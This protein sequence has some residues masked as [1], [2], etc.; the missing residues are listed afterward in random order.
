MSSTQRELLGS[1]MIYTWPGRV[2]LGR[3]LAEMIQAACH[4]A[5]RLHFQFFWRIHQTKL[6]SL[7][8][9]VG[10]G[11]MLTLTSLLAACWLACR[12]TSHVHILFIILKFYS[13]QSFFS[14]LSPVSLVNV[15]HPWPTASHKQLHVLF[16]KPPSVLESV[17]EDW[18]Q[19][20]SGWSERYC[21]GVS[22]TDVELEWAGISVT[23]PIKL[24]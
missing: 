16:L 11:R 24:F 14:P 18:R 3:K 15:L 9:Q 7:A 8:T 13:L 21:Q 23:F 5:P 22:M 1:D 6:I 2:L 12:P 10:K 17:L 4:I 20:Q 19:L